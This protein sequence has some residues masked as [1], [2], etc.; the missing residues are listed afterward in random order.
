MSGK[1]IM[2]VLI[3]SCAT[4]GGHYAAAEAMQKELQC[5][6]IMY[7]YLIPMCYLEKL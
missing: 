4:G 5:R 7:S 3:L 2:E 6:D 1:D